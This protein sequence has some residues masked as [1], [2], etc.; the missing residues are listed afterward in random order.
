MPVSNVSLMAPQ[1]WTAQQEDIAR[2]RKLAE[3]MQTQATQPIERFSA[4]NTGEAPISWTQGLAKMLQAYTGAKQQQALTQEQKDLYQQQQGQYTQAGQQLMNAV[5]PR[6]ATEAQPNINPVDDNGTPMPGTAATPAYNPT[7]DDLMKA[8]MKYTSDIGRPDLGAQFAMTHASQAMLAKAL[9]GDQAPPAQTGAPNVA[10]GQAMG[11]ELQ[12]QTQGQ[13]PGAQPD[14]PPIPKALA[15]RLMLQDPTGGKL[16]ALQSDMYK[17]MSAP[18]NLREGST[19][20][21]PGHGPLF[22]APKEGRVTT[23][24]NGQ[25]QMSV[26]PGAAQAL[27]SVAQAEAGGKAAGQSP[28]ETVPV[29]S[30][31]G[32]TV[33]QF[34]TQLPGYPG[35]QPAQPNVSQSTQSGTLPPSVPPSDAQAFNF[36]NSAQG[37]A[38]AT[39]GPDGQMQTGV[40]VPQEQNNPWATMPRR[41]VPQGMG[42]STYDKQTAEHQAE[43]TSK[44]AEKYGSQAQS[45]DQRLAFNNQALDLVD[46]AD[47]GTY[48]T[49]IADVKNFLTSRVGIPEDR[50]QNTPSATL[51]LQKDLVSAATQRAKQQFGSR[52][53]QNEVML[54]LN[55]GAPNA[56]MTKASIKYLLQSDNAQLGYAKQQAQDF[57]KYMQNGGDPYRFDSW[58]SSNFPMTKAIEGVQLKTGTP[59]AQDV[60][61]EMRRRGLAK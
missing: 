32:A 17:Q 50:F 39:M 38:S 45:A 25:P 33:P 28:Y 51:A 54:M 29:Q 56:D 34:K 2:R 7:Q 3:L 23:Y 15:L 24:K 11:A 27:G 9:L 16:M 43:A 1:D 47:N 6:P 36:V 13:P 55:K 30:A 48:A 35:G 10:Q 26:M 53:T 18:V 44:L 52:I 21:Q 14:I 46:K 19:V 40:P 20:Y 61:D 31:G 12:G 4:P 58:Y 5:T 57:G 59:S 22:V 37:P 8:Q 49:K 42:Q 41:T 60:F